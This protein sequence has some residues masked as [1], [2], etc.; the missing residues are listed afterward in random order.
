MHLRRAEAG[1]VPA[2]AALQR[3]AY[4]DLRARIGMS[5]QP[6][7]A[8]FAAVF[9]TTEI[10]LAG[11]SEKL[12]AALILDAKPDHLLI[13]SIAVAPERKGAG[14]GSALLDFAEARAAEAGLPEVRLYTN[15]RFTENVAWYRRRGYA[16]ERI[17]ERP[18]RRVVHFRRAVRA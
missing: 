12:D 7:D 18:D 10:W 3:A 9:A 11:P 14:L 1:D 2:L 17:E 8:D 16:V 6:Y 5:L 4:A 13:W 15:E